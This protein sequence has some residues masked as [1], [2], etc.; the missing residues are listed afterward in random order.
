MIICYPFE[1]Y[2][3][4]KI[5]KD[6]FHFPEFGFHFDVDCLNHNAMPH[7]IVIVLIQNHSELLSI[8]FTILSGYYHP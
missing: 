2:I 5:Y 4:K 6:T 8:R 1:Y 7:R 3:G